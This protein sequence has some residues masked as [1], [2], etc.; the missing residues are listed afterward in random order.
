M[1]MLLALQRKASPNMIVKYSR[2]YLVTLCHQLAHQSRNSVVF[3]NYICYF[4][5]DGPV[6][7]CAA[8]QGRRLDYPGHS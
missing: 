5:I 6:D 7:V 3:I 2:T 4:L 8:F 1:E